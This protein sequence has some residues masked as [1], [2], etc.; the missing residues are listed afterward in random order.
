MTMTA[1]NIQSDMIY[2][3]FTKVRQARGLN[4]KMALLKHA[5]HEV[6]PHVKEALVYCYHP[7]WHY[8]IKASHS[9]VTGL[10]EREWTT[11]I[12]AMLL[13]MSHGTLS[14]Y[15]A[16][17][18]LREAL[19][20]LT[21]KSAMLLVYVINKHLDIG[22]GVKS[23][24]KVFPYLIPVHAIQLANP[25]DYRRVRYPAM[26]SPKLDGLRATFKYGKFYSRLGNEFQG[27]DKLAAQVVLPFPNAHLDGE[28][29][30]EGE[31]FNEI[32]GQ[33]RSFKETDNA[34]FNVFDITNYEAP[35]YERYRALQKTQF[36]GQV[37][38]VEHVEAYDEDDIQDLYAEAL[39]NGYEGVMVKNSSAIYENARSWAWMKVKPTH[40]KDLKVIGTFEG[41]GKY[42]GMCG[43]LIVQH[44]NVPVRV[45]SGLSDVQRGLWADDSS[46]II[47]ATV[48]V[49]Y[50]EITPDGSLRHPRLKAVRGDK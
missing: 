17:R 39:A 3:I 30:V 40:T 15:A 13:S 47:G 37:K 7:H 28:L 8:G 50:Q 24:N 36:Q 44:E 19:K 16:K 34:T 29:M 41:H 2:D 45:G 46:D 27:L 20:T 9:L 10:G 23:I 43:G 18:A 1:M 32:S 33:L 49:A 6:L 21:Y 48:E 31:H 11:D 22:M 12:F 14:G 26:V 38:L 35:L 4:A 5:P 42:E 25:I